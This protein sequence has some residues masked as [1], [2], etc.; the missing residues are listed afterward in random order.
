[1]TSRPH[2]DEP[3]FASLLFYV[4]FTVLLYKYFTCIITKIQNRDFTRVRFLKKKIA[5]HLFSLDSPTEDAVYHHY[6]V[7]GELLAL[8]SKTHPCPVQL[9]RQDSVT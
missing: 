9:K 7:M 4:S 1:M 6:P 8:T 5:V 2:L 3:C